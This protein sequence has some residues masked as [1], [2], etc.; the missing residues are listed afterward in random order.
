VK[1]DPRHRLGDRAEEAAAALYEG[2]GF[3]VVDRNVRVGRLEIDLIVSRGGMLVFVEV[4]S[5]RAG[6]MVHPALTIRGAKAQ[7]MRQA[8]AMWLQSNG[9]RGRVVRMDVVAASELPDRTF[10]LEVYENV[11]SG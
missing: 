6:G 10:E 11:L 9:A 2:R 1:T 8:A 4:R 5:R 7:H 3:S